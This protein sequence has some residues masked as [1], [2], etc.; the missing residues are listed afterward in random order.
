MIG[1]HGPC[2]FESEEL[3]VFDCQSVL[4]NDLAWGSVEIAG[5]R[6]VFQPARG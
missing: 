4:A 5:P 6:T 3:G 1:I 2:G